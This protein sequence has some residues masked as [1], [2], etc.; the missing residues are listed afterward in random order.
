MTTEGKARNIVR[1]LH[2][3]LQPSD[4]G[5]GAVLRGQI[6]VDSLCFLDLP[7]YQRNDLH[8]KSISESFDNP[9]TRLPDVELGMRGHDYRRVGDT[10]ELYDPV[11]II[12]GWQRISG[13][14]HY[15]VANGDPDKVEIGAVVHFDT[16]PDWEK[17][18]FEILN[19][20][21]VRVSSDLLLRN[22]R[23]R[24]PALIV[25]HDLSFKDEDFPLCNRVSWKQQRSRR[26]LIGARVLLKV[27]MIIHSPFY[28]AGVQ[29]FE[30]LIAGSD[31]LCKRIGPDTFRANV[32]CFFNTIEDCWG[33]RE[34]TFANAATSIKEGFLGCV[35]RAMADHDTFWT[36][37]G[38]R[39]KLFVSRKLRSK[40]RSFELKGVV[41]DLAGGGSEHKSSYLLLYEM[42]LRHVNSGK[43]QRLEPRE[44]VEWVDIDDVSPP[45][46]ADD[47]DDDLGLRP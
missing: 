2:G 15:L 38:V 20:R 11:E 46:P 26:D 8:G 40:F 23:D 34:L 44:S 31:R 29:D 42:F 18:R 45:P 25:L 37:P 30:N 12:D 43:R 14:L 35:A 5:H 17:D 4:R 3:A 28:K 39:P 10:F 33:I 13:A 36:G 19:R 1:I 9:D 7:E 16:S 27:A 6:D 22:R 41:A 47:D 32:K 24:H 21:R